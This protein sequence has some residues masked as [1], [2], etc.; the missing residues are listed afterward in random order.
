VIVDHAIK[1]INVSKPTG[2]V[3]SWYGIFENGNLVNLVYD[4]EAARMV[5]ESRKN[6][7]LVY[8]D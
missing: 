2:V 1:C 3:A 6:E 8:D 5:V 7:W 4:Y